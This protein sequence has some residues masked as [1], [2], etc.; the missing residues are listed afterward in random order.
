[1]PMFVFQCQSCNKTFEKLF[2]HK[3]SFPIATQLDE[4]INAG[5]EC[6][7]K[8]IRLAG[9]PSLKFV[10]KD[11]YVTEERARRERQRVSNDIKTANE[12]IA[13][14]KRESGTT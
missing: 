12:N 8:I 10:G 1:M 14:S 13:K 2:L 9:V 11:F 3:V 7:G 6:G 4:F 5:C